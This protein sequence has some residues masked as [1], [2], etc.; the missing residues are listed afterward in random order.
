MNYLIEGLQGSG[1]STLVQKLSEKN[2]SYIVYHEGDYSPI[3]LAWCAYTSEEQYCQILE[4][5]REIR[6]LIE[7]KTIKEGDRR[8]ICYTQVKTDD[9]S[10]Y[11]DL[12]QYEIYHQLVSYENFKS[13]KLN[14]YAQWKQDNTISECALFQNTVEDMILFRQASDEEIISFFQQVRDALKEKPYQIIYLK[15]DDIKGNL[16]IIRN[17]RTDD[18]GNEL[19][20]PMMCGY[21]N[22]SSYAKS[23][24]LKDESGLLTHFAHR[25]ELELRICREVFPNHIT[26]LP[27]K[28]YRDEEISN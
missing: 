16:D 1:K 8:I 20:F 25:Q 24:H 17:E 7:A 15:T 4:K 21:F 22:E 3:E 18:Q 2:P 27:S 12:E 6:P 28:A 23:H 11:Q 19:W 14:R 10:F 26:I 5:H 13:I 9:P